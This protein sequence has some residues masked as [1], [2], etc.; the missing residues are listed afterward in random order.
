MNVTQAQLLRSARSILGA[1]AKNL[2]LNIILFV[3]IKSL[4]EQQQQ[5]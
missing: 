2:T 5:K 1:P 3:V 4:G